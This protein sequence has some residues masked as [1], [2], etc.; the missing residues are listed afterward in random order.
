[1]NYDYTLIE[2][3]NWSKKEYILIDGSCHI[4]NEGQ[5][6]EEMIDIYEKEL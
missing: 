4:K 6:F 5:C 1:M 2:V 3:V